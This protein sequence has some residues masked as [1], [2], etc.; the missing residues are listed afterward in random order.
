MKR[1]LDL[2]RSILLRVESAEG[3]LSLDDF[4]SEVYT[5]PQVAYHLGLMEDQ[6][7]I[8]A[9]FVREWSGAS[10]KATVSGLTWAGADYLDAVRDDRVWA[11]V[12]GAV[13]SAGAFTFGAVKE[14]AV[15]VAVASAKASLGI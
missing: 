2:A 14:V 7:L 4:A 6:G 15:A 12:Q 1:D 8:D 9:T 5:V 3:P 11:K 13:K 10:V